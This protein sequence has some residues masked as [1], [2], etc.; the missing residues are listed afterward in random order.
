M[1]QPRSIVT[2]AD[3]TGAKKVGVFSSAGFFF[4]KFDNVI[5]TPVG[6]FENEWDGSS[7]NLFVG[8]MVYPFR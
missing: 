8:A 7:F 3:N 5:E 4:T 2:V 6:R 1:L